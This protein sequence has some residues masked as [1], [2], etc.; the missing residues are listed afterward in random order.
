L[1]VVAY[2]RIGRVE[3]HILIGGRNLDRLGSCSEA[4]LSVLGAG[5][6]HVH[7]KAGQSNGL[8]AFVREFDSVTWSRLDLV[9]RIGALGVGDG[10]IRIAGLEIRE[11]DTNTSDDG[12]GRIADDTGDGGDILGHHL[13]WQRHHQSEQCQQRNDQRKT[14]GKMR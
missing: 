12:A 11:S 10:L 8:K 6:V 5:G 9:D 13:S 1:K 4:H 2:R 3:G 14:S 7:V